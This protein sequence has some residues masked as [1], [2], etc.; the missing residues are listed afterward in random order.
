MLNNGS[1]THAEDAATAVRNKN[2]KNLK[3]HGEAGGDI[4]GRTVAVL[5]GASVDGTVDA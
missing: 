1:P 4:A 5:E 2:K 3:I